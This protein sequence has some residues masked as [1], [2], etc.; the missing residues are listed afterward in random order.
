MSWTPR[1]RSSA[2]TPA[3]NFAPS[4]FCTQ[5]PSTRLGAVGVHPITWWADL[6]RT[7]LFSLTLT[8]IASKY[9]IGCADRFQRPVLPGVHLVEHR[10]GDVRDGFVGQ[11]HTQRALKVGLDVRTVIPPAYNEMIMSDNPEPNRRSPW[12]PAAG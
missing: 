3:Q 6:L 11:L 2:H 4:V 10:V 7:W 8:T 12:V 5:I 9:T 1:L